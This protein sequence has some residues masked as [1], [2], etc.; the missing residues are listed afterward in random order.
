V[1]TIEMLPAGNGDSLWI[2]YGRLGE[3]RH[4][5]IDGGTG[6]TYE[7]LR[8]RFEAMPVRERRLELLVVTHIDGDHIDGA[9][10][11][12]GDKSLRVKY[13][14]IWFNGWPHLVSSDELGPVA[15]ER[16][17]AKIRERKL[18]WNKCFGGGPV[19][20]VARKLWQQ[21]VT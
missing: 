3:V 20:P 10:K 4:M 21:T 1:L 19:I 6:P 18:R 17:S 9:L 5:L 13:G 11:L 16:L 15:G 12:L 2:E 7:V 8:R 14:D